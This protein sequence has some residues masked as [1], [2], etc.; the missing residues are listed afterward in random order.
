[1]SETFETNYEFLHRMAKEFDQRGMTYL[2]SMDMGPREDGGRT[3][4]TYGRDRLNDGL[5]KATADC[6]RD[7]VDGECYYGPDDDFEN[8]LSKTF[9]LDE[10]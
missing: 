1:M 7:Y 3:I 4:R 8:D 10:Q 2:I 6:A 5:I 9:E